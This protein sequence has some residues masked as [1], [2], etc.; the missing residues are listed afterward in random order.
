MLEINCDYLPISIWKSASDL[1][2]FRASDNHRGRRP[3]PAQVWL[4]LSGF[5]NLGSSLRRRPPF[6]ASGA[7][8]LEASVLSRL[9][10][11]NRAWSSRSS[12]FN[13]REMTSSTLSFKANNSSKG[14]EV[15][16][17]IDFKLSNIP[18]P[19]MS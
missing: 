13:R 15:K 7:G 2:D 1:P 4:G 10:R 18:R 16:E 17:S 12:D 5:R 11:V 9:M 6:L 3:R 14:I 8:G 19:G